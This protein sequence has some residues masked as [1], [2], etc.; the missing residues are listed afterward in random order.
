V[1]AGT[2]AYESEDAAIVLTCGGAAACAAFDSELRLVQPYT[3]DLAGMLRDLYL[4]GSADDPVSNEDVRLV[5]QTKTGRD[6][7]SFFRDYIEGAEAIPASSF[8]SLKVV[9]AQDSSL[10]LENE[11]VSTSTSGWILLIIAVVL[12]FIIPFV[13]EPYTMKPRKPGFLKKKLGEED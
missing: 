1:Q 9:E 11:E 10:P 6:W 2:Q 3:S 4:A 12:V 7:S 8:S 13:L 5:L